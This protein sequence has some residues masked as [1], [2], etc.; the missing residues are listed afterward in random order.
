M[1]G[2]LRISNIT[3]TNK[4]KAIKLFSMAVGMTIVVFLLSILF[5]TN[6]A[7]ASFLTAIGII[8]LFGVAMWLVMQFVMTVSD[9]F[10]QSN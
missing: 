7:H 5:K 4:M 9:F 6:N 10:K 3:N 8:V 1:Q 2:V